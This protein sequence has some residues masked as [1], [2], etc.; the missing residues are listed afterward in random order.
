MLNELKGQVVVITGG[1]SGIGAAFARRF[2]EEGAK[3]VICDLTQEKVD[4][5]VAELA[6]N[7]GD[8]VGFVCDVTDRADVER[9]AEFAWARHG[10][11]DIALHNAGKIAPQ[12]PVLDAKRQDID[13][14]FEVNLFG[15]LNSIQVFGRRFVKQNTPAAM[16]IIGSENS[17]FDGVP[18]GSAYVASKHA[19]LAFAD[20]LRKELPEFIQT[21]FICP[22]IVATDLTQRTKEMG[23]DPD[24]F[25]RTVMP[26]IKAGHFFAVSHAYNIVPIKERFSEI[27][28]A[29]DEFAPRYEGDIEFDVRDM[30][31]RSIK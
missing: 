29:Y 20:A 10:R 30:V 14:V 7:G 17:L 18:L 19:I 28:A 26:Q 13:A 3:A 25:T 21:S 2:L 1:A 5:A 31:R 4:A 8:V 6:A 9:L 16:L 27:Q 24:L 11:V 23:M 22:G 15:M 12:A